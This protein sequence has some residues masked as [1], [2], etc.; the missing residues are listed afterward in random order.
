MSAKNADNYANHDIGGGRDDDIGKGLAVDEL[1]GAVQLDRIANING[2]AI[3]CGDGILPDNAAVI[4]QARQIGYGTKPEWCVEICHDN[5]PLL[6]SQREAIIRQR[7][8][9]MELE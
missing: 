1:R 9:S 2:G 5:G 7:S 4:W 3:G 8:T 6:R